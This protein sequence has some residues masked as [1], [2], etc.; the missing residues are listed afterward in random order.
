MVF[1]Y[2]ILGLYRKGKERNQPSFLLS[3]AL[4][5]R[6]KGELSNFL[7]GGGSSKWMLIFFKP[8]IAKG[9]NLPSDTEK[10]PLISD[11]SKWSLI[12]R[13]ISKVLTSGS[14]ERSVKDEMYSLA[15][16]RV[17][18]N[19]YLVEVMC[20]MNTKH[21]PAVVFWR[22]NVKAVLFNMKWKLIRISLN[23]PSVDSTI[24][25]MALGGSAYSPCQ[26]EIFCH[27]G[28]YFQRT[29]GQGN[30][31]ATLGSIKKKE[32]SFLLDFIL[33][34]LAHMLVLKCSELNG[35][36]WKVTWNGK[37]GFIVSF[38]DILHFL[39]LCKTDTQVLLSAALRKGRTFLQWKKKEKCR[40]FS[41]LNFLSNDLALHW[42]KKRI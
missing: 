35:F 14:E 4:H 38:A 37:Q 2:Y 40:R 11:L 33:L 12:F 23:P 24:F 28:N 10:H 9:T 19:S 32:F 3:Q 34:A 27:N 7:S 17:S 15:M 8:L 20:C 16:H 31:S 25:V 5:E 39:S 30:E 26:M 1:F 41:C 13:K 29:D 6:K 18:E 21:Q 42:N 22:Q 36:A